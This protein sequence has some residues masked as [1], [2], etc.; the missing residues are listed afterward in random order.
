MSGALETI[1]L[2]AATLLLANIFVLSMLFAMG[3]L[4]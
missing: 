4:R 3:V 2:A 1:R